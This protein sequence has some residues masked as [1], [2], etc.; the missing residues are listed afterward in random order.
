[1]LMEAGLHLP[2]TYASSSLC[3]SLIEGV[4][5]LKKASE[6]CVPSNCRKFKLCD[7]EEVLM[8]SQVFLVICSFFY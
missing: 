6:I 3:N 7:A 2:V 1:M 5:W 8:Q 4:N